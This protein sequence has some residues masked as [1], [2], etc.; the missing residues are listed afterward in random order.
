[1]AWTVQLLLVVGTAAAHPACPLGERLGQ[2]RHLDTPAEQGA[3]AWQPQL[4]GALAPVDQPSSEPMNFWTRTR[5]LLRRMLL[6][7]PRTTCMLER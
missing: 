7:R 1:M 6:K 4:L 3:R 2:K 5:R